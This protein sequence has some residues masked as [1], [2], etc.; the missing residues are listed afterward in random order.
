MLPGDT[1]WPGRGQPCHSPLCWRL[2]GRMGLTH[3]E[4]Q[5]KQVQALRFSPLTLSPS[6][7]LPLIPFVHGGSEP[8]PGAIVKPIPSPQWPLGAGKRMPGCTH[9]ERD[10]PHGQE[11]AGGGQSCLLSCHGQDAAPCLRLTASFH[12]ACQIARNLSWSCLGCK[13]PLPMGRGNVW[14]GPI[15]WD[16]CLKLQPGTGCAGLQ[17]SRDSPSWSM[18]QTLAG[19]G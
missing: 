11:Q 15:S 1:G 19:G 13:L 18:P 2:C 14:D 5:D 6:A 9:S 10:A 16:W 12:P 3:S 7:G 8:S 17:Q 4:T